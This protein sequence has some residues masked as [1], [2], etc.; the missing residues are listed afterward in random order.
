MCNKHAR[1]LYGIRVV[2][3]SMGLLSILCQETDVSQNCFH[4]LFSFNLPIINLLCRG[5]D[6]KHLIS[7]N[8]SHVTLLPYTKP[9]YFSAKQIKF[10][11]LCYVHTL[12]HNF[13]HNFLRSKL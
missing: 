5:Y 10:R 11:Q 3:I 2:E 13:P 9:Q 8:L 1:L 7:W 12:F 6:E 4:S